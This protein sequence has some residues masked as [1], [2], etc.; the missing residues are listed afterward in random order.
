MREKTSSLF[1]IITAYGVIWPL[2]SA[3]AECS[4][5]A[6]G[7]RSSEAEETSTESDDDL[8]ATA[9]ATFTD[10]TDILP[11][12]TSAG[13]DE[14]IPTGCFSMAT[15]VESCAAQTTGFLELEYISQAP[16]FWYVTTSNCWLGRNVVL[17]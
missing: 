1:I 8:E 5:S 9:T 3:Q 4:S 16:C 12:A 11:T 15:L 6:S 13:N 17:M 14:D 10:L 2:C 7:T